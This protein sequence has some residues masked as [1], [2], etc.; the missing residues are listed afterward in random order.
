MSMEG[1]S[2]TEIDEGSFTWSGSCLSDVSTL[3]KSPIVF[4]FGVESR[5]DSFSTN[6]VAAANLKLEESAADY[7]RP[8]FMKMYEVSQIMQDANILIEESIT[9]FFGTRF[10]TL[11]TEL[12]YTDP[13][14]KKIIATGVPYYSTSSFF[15]ETLSKDPI[16]KSNHF[17][18]Y[19]S[20]YDEIVGMRK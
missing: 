2:L 6:F 16:T 5:T 11:D 3:S 15:A 18:L 7:G 8:L 4:G 19:P 12:N 10:Q 1:N 20:H 9:A 17:V 14:R 13:L